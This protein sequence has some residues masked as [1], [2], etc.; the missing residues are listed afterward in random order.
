MHL[1]P[2]MLPKQIE[3]RTWNHCIPTKEWTVTIVA[4]ICL[5]MPTVY[6][7]FAGLTLV[8]IGSFY[9]NTHFAPLIEKQLKTNEA[10]FKSLRGLSK[11]KACE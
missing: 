6:G 11:H 2:F 8:L 10:H 5:Q 4:H 3:P 7:I 1:E 9:N